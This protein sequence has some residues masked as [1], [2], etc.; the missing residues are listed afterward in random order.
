MANQNFI[1]RTTLEASLYSHDLEIR[2]LIA[3]VRDVQTNLKEGVLDS[4]SLIKLAISNQ[5]EILNLIRI[6]QI[7][8]ETNIQNVNDKLADEIG[9]LTDY[10]NQTSDN[11]AMKI[12]LIRKFSFVSFAI[13]SLMLIC[14][15]VMLWH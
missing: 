7:D 14:I 15:G 4:H 9:C 10:V 1:H 2:K 3:E 11:I 5:T 8:L 6:N 13:T 12:R